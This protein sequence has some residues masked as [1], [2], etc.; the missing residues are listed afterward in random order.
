ML[1]KFLLSFYMYF[2][3]QNITNLSQVR[4]FISHLLWAQPLL[5]YIL[6]PTL[7]DHCDFVLLICTVVAE[8]SHII[9]QQAQ[10]LDRARHQ[11]YFVGTRTPIFSTPYQPPDMLIIIDPKGRL[12]RWGT[13][14]TCDQRYL[15]FRYSVQVHRYLNE[16]LLF[17]LVL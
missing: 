11:R 12:L 2:V 8:Q 15:R 4:L 13:V 1:S 5:I 16:Q 7:C 3:W 17:N 10:S 9:L 6:M 14:H